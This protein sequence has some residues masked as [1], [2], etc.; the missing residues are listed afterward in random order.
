[1]SHGGSTC[2]SCSTIVIFI[3]RPNVEITIPAMASFLVLFP[4]KPMIDVMRL[5][6][7]SK[8]LALKHPK[9]DA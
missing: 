3:N 2:V 4:R 7:K 6:G 8:K 9:I 5:S 1:M